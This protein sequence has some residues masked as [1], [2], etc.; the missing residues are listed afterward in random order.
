[1]ISWI[2]EI[3]KKLKIIKERRDEFKMVKKRENL[4]VLGM[5]CL[6]IALLFDIFGKSN[7]ILDIVILLFIGIALFS[8][9]GYLVMAPSEKKKK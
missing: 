7:F 4:L 6:I 3:Q 5:V 1:M 9:A 8:N 2:G